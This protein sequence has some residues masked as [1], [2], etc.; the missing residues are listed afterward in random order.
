M[1]VSASTWK[2]ITLL[3]LSSLTVMSGATIAPSL[4]EM[5]KVFEFHPRAD[6]YVKLVLTMPALMI[7]LLAPLAG[8]VVDRM[9][10]RGLILISLVLYG[11]AGCSGL[12]VDSLEVMLIGR[13]FLGAAVAGL[14]TATTTLI[15]DYFKGE[16]RTDFL[17][18]Q[19]AYMALG[20]VVFLLGGGGLA[21]LHWRAPFTIYGLAFVL[22]P[23]VLWFIQ[24]PPRVDHHTLKLESSIKEVHW[25][26]VAFLFVMGGLGM[27]FFYMIPV[28]LP[29]FLKFQFQTSNTQVGFAIA[30]VTLCGAVTAMQYPRLKRKL[31][32]QLLLAAHLLG[33][34]IGFCLLSYSRSY[35]QALGCLVFSGLGS[36]L[37]MPNLNVWLLSITPESIRGRVIGGITMFFFIGQFLSPIVTSPRGPVTTLGGA[38]GVAGLVLLGGAILFVVGE[39]FR[40]R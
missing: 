8:V 5:K 3:L 11:L 38:Y 20:G 36:G 31:S 16:E 24:E 14:M 17:G 30:L 32:F 4:P 18:K 37:L 33:M 34:G 13:A 6:L 21:D 22:V 23:A 15:G 39:F 27:M 12:V 35:L 9:G 1:E 29:F 40:T 2:K 28:Q 19:A 10:R 7:A 25:G 26:M